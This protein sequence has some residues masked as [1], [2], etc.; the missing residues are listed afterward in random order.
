MKGRAIIP[1][2]YLDGIRYQQVVLAGCN[3]IIAHEKELNRINVFPI[4]DNDTG[5]NL[6]KTLLPLVY[7]Y[8]IRRA[9]IDR[10][11]REIADL[12]MQSALGYSG[13]IFSQIL[14]GF[15][16]GLL[17]TDRIQPQNLGPVTELAVRKAYHSIKHP[18]E[19]TLLS[20]LKA[21][22][23]EINRI[24]PATQDFSEILER[25]YQEALR[26]LEH[27]PEQLEILKKNRV[28]DA[29][30]KAWV[31]FLEGI[32]RFSKKGKLY[33][34]KSQTAPSAAT[35]HRPKLEAPYCAECCVKGGN[36]DRIG[37]IEKL[38]GI[39]QDLIFYGAAHFAKIHIKAHD[40]EKVFSCVSCF[41]D[42]S[43]RKIFRSNGSTSGEEVEP[44][45]LIADSTCDISDG[46]IEKN[47]VYFVPIK[48]QAGEK[49]YTDRWDLIPEEFYDML[50]SSPTHPQTSQPSLM[51][52]S[53]IFNHL[54]SHYRSIISIHLSHALS[55]TFQTAL[56]ASYQTA[57][58]RISVVDA[59][60]ISVGLGLILLEAIRALRRS[61]NKEETLTVIEK[62]ANAT[63]IFIG[64]PTLKFLVK[65]GRI[66]KSKGLIAEI[67][68]INPIL[69]I[70]SEGKLIPIAKARGKKRLEEKVMELVFDQ[71]GKKADRI[72]V[73][74][75]HTNALDIGNR[76]ARRLEDAFGQSVDLIRN[77]SPALGAHAGPGAFGVAV[78]AADDH[79]VSDP[80]LTLKT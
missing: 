69:T 48:V 55:G 47:P 4:P 42:T 67:L 38:N 57:P 51:D 45:C 10:I 66:T 63:K 21:W 77:A 61:R 15:A 16:E 68:G 64:L 1:I 14:L 58:E 56:Q 75:A 52:F 44:V 19:G 37:L 60:S 22:S 29:G 54:L 32:L 78:L 26:A 80:D 20:V 5:S 46:L 17:T 24:S 49:I 18:C 79:S 76:M 3:E 70:D 74:V 2:S 40:P 6:K 71:I 34:Y 8:P 73:A 36:L 12:A 30:G 13:I 72:S 35:I 62:A 25:S 7:R 43:S 33:K 11:S 41:G 53:L 28:V 50:L 65:G 39:G 27:T 31:Y 9:K 23:Q 59:N